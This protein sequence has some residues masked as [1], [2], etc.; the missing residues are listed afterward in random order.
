MNN[1]LLKSQY[2]PT[3]NEGIDP[4]TLSYHSF[5]EIWWI[6]IDHV[7]CKE[8]VWKSTISNRTKGKGCPFCAHGGQGKTC[9]CMS[10]FTTHPR[11]CKDIPEKNNP[12]IDT[13]KI[14]YGS[15]QII[16]YEC[17]ICKFNWS[18]TVSNRTQISA[19]DRCPQCRTKC[20]FSDFENNC[21]NILIKN[22]ITLLLQYQFSYISSRK[23]DFYFKYNGVNY[24][25]E[26]DG[27]QHFHPSSKFH[28]KIE[29]FIHQQNADKI[30]TIVP[31]LYNYVIIRLSNDNFEHIENCINIILNL[32]LDKPAI[33]MD[34]ITMY[35]Y[36][37]KDTF[38]DKNNVDLL[39]DEFVNKEYRTEAKKIY[40]E[41]EY[42]LFD[43]KG[44]IKYTK[45]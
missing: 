41:R 7:L 25:I 11:L 5:V 30:K 23:F 1:P 3:K 16:N 4:W 39:I 17:F 40:K 8:H 10:I 45:L 35:D 32:K 28:L 6:C 42:D 37:I 38:Y 36:I 12:G 26:T 20:N 31:L 15:H 18:S 27:K 13:K 14:S 9:L 22:Q 44:R 19:S 24:I 21:N 34:D 43:I 33:I 2:H 29:D